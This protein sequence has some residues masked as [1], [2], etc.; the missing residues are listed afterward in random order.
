MTLEG[1][2]KAPKHGDA[3]RIRVNRAVEKLE[4]LLRQR[5]VTPSHL[6]NPK[7]F[8]RIPPVGVV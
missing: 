7:K 6:A 3:A 4:P 2:R 8:C 5:D 1:K